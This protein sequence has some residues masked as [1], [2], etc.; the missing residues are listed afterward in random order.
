M[1]NLKSEPL[2]WIQVKLKERI[3]YLQLTGKERYQYLEEQEGMI[4]NFLL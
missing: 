2:L 1:S 3:L 4:C